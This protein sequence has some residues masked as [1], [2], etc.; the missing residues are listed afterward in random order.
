[1]GYTINKTTHT[2]TVDTSMTTPEIGK[3]LNE[4]LTT[5]REQ[6]IPYITWKIKSNEKTTPIS[7]TK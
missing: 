1:M 2:I 4:M 7:I 6:E 5:E 3:L